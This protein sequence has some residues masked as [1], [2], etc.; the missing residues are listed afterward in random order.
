[1]QMARENSG[2]G[3]D[4]IAGALANLGHAVSDQTVGNVLRRHGIAPAPKRSQTTTW[5]DFIT[6]HMAVLAGMD[7][8]TAEVLTWRGPATYYV[9]FF[10]QLETRRVTLA[11]MTQHPTEEWMQ[12]VAR[13][14]TDA[15][16]GALREQRYL[17]HDRDTKFG[18]RFRSTLRAGGIEPLLLSA[19]SPNLK[20][21]ASHCTSF[22]LTDVTSLPR[23][24]SESLWPWALCGR[25]AAGASYRHSFLSL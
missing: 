24:R 18:D 13:N 8:F 11:G 1:M 16:S 22:A 12:Q 5:K 21:Y 9:L 10:I 14:L 2:W 23:P 19:S 7:F 3:Y 25:L 20:D 15:D 6:A 4:R 17:L